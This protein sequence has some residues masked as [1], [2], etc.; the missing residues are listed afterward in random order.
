VQTTILYKHL[1]SGTP[2]W[3]VASKAAKWQFYDHNESSAKT[4][5]FLEIEAGDVDMFISESA[6]M[7][8]DLEKFTATFYDA[9]SA[10]VCKLQF[11]D[12]QVCRAFHDTYQN[13]L[14][15]NM[16]SN[17][18]IQVEDDKGGWFFQP[19][20][21]TPME[22]DPSPEDGPSTPTNVDFRQTEGPSQREVVGVTMGA[23]DNSFLLQQG[24]VSVYR[25]EGFA[26]G[27]STPSHSFNL[28]PLRQ[29][30]AGIGETASSLTPGRAILARGE[31]QMNMLT[32]QQRE[33]VFQ[34]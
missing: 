5:W 26:E 17:N 19:A 13:K 30:P 34:V 4:A 8:T 32:P 15:E 3:N 22:W 16:C 28:T 25:N 1:L 33:V 23:M 14:Y 24:S 7:Q 29:R 11:P 27:V 9:E 12:L 10:A 18:N 21:A 2:A 20:E 6:E 31:T